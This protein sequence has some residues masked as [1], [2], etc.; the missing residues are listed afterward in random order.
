MYASIDV[1]VRRAYDEVMAVTIT[2]FRK[3]LFR[4]ADQA[5]EGEPVEFIHKGVLFK[6]TPETRPSKLSRLTK[7]P[8]VAPGADLETEELLKEMEAEWRK[9]W[10]EI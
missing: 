6:V 5:L 3:N 1:Y 2:E 9:D 10:S 4:L 8:V 7:E